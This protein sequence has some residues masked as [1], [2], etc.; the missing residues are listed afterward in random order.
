MKVI[1]Y[2]V[3]DSFKSSG[4]VRHQPNICLTCISGP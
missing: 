1:F 3:H 4:A 2:S